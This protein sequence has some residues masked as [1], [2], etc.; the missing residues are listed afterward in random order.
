MTIRELLQTVGS[1]V[2]VRINVLG[3]HELTGVC[4]PRKTQNIL[5]R[6]DAMSCTDAYVIRMCPLFRC[7]EL[8]IECVNI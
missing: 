3:Q 2:A 1:D 8:Y 6:L 5:R 7:R 4:G